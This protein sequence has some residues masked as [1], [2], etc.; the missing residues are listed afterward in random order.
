MRWGF[1]GTDGSWAIE[2][3]FEAVGP[4]SEGLA[5]ASHGA[6]GYID[7]EGA[8]VVPFE[9][10]YAAA[11]HRGMANAAKPNAVGSFIDRSGRALPFGERFA[12]PAHPEL[13]G[14]TG[15]REKWDGIR[16]AKRSGVLAADSLE[17][18]LPVRFAKV[19][20][21]GPA[22]LAAIDDTHDPK[23]VLF[24]A[25]VQPVA[26]LPIQWTSAYGCGAYLVFDVFEPG[27]RSSELAA[28]DADTFERVAT[29]ED[30]RHMH[31]GYDPESDTYSLLRQRQRRRLDDALQPTDEV[32]PTVFESFRV[33]PVKSGKRTRIEIDGEPIGVEVDKTHRAGAEDATTIWAMV[34]TGKAKRWG[35]LGVDG[36]IVEPEHELFEREGPYW[37]VGALG[38]EGLVDADGRWLLE[39]VHTR[40]RHC[41]EH[42]HAFYEGG[43]AFKN[44][45]LKGGA[46]RVTRPDGSPLCQQTF[47]DV[48]EW[49]EDRLAAALD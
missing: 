6:W 31:M 15:Y 44:G 21:L 29:Y 20:D 27:R 19:T 22:F 23:T 14:V 43:K 30:S 25:D 26:E 46:W 18:R 42:G 24:D 13:I 48:G 38:S 1:L 35:L 32:L 2:P 28:Y 8:T 47:A 41:G 36:W 12:L 7:R 11:F 45:N 37:R 39:P 4:F 9:L 10:A 33:T 5:A 34:K 17:E 49:R 3:S 40:V 16:S